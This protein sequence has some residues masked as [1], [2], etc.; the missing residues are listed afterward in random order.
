[1]ADSR[2][3]WPTADDYQSAMQNLS[4]SMSDT[5]LQS[6]VA[7][8][9]I[10]GMPLL[11]SGGIADVY[12]VECA[13]TGN[14][15]AVKCF[16]R[17]TAGLQERYAKISDCL[18]EKRLPFMVDFEYLDKGIRIA[19]HWYPI[20][21]MQW[22][23]GQTLGEYIQSN[24]SK[25]EMLDQ[26]LLLWVK[27]ATWLDRADIAHADLQ[28]G[29]VMLVPVGDDGTV[30]LKLVDYDGM[31]VPALAGSQATE[32]GHPNFQHPQRAR[33]RIYKYE[34]DRFSH[35][36]IC[37]AI[38]SLRVGGR[39][40]WSDFDNED[41]LLFT[42]K[43]FEVPSE[44]RLMKELWT[45]TDRR[46]HTLLGNLILATQNPLQK[47]PLIQQL[48]IDGQSEQLSVEASQR[49][50]SILGETLTET[51]VPIAEHPKLKEIET[52]S[53]K[54]TTPPHSTSSPS[55]EE[56]EAVNTWPTSHDFQSAMLNLSVSMSDSELQSGV[57]AQNHLGLPL[58]YS[59]DT[60]EVYRV[61]CAS[62][63]NT[64]AVKCFRQPTAELQERYAK[65]SKCLRE[66]RLPFMVNF[67]F[68][69][70]G[71][72]I[73]N[74]WYPIL[75]MQW[76][77]GKT[78]NEYVKEI[79]DQPRM[80]EQLLRLWVKLAQWL[81]NADIA[82]GDLQHGS[83]LIIPIGEDGTISLKLVDYDGMWVPALA[84]SKA[85]EL[86][87]PNFQHPQRAAKYIYSKD[88]DRFSHL[89]ICTAISCLK[90]GGRS[91]W[92]GFD[93][94]D[95]VLFMAKDFALP[96]E[97]RLMRELWTLKDP[98]SRV[99]VGHLIVA[100]RQ[101]LE[102]V[103]PVYDLVQDHS[104]TQ[105]RLRE[106]DSILSMSVHG[107][108][109]QPSRNVELN[110]PTFES[111]EIQGST[112]NITQP[113][114]ATKR[115][116]NR[117]LEKSDE[118]SKKY[119]IWHRFIPS[120][121]VL[122]GVVIVI[123]SVI[124]I[125]FLESFLITRKQ[126]PRLDNSFR[127]RIVTNSIGMEL[128]RISAGTFVMGSPENESYHSLNEIQH[129]VTISKPF[130]ISTTE[131]TQEQWEDVM[132][133]S[134]WEGQEYCRDGNDYPAVYVSWSDAIEFCRRL[135]ESEGVE[136]SLP[137]EAQWEYACRAGSSSAYNFGESYKSLKDHAWYWNNATR[138]T[139]AFSFGVSPERFAREVAKKRPNAWGLFDMH[140][141]AAEWCLDWYDYRYYV[142]SPTSDPHGPTSGES[143]VTRGGGF[144][145]GSA[146]CRSANRSMN[147]LRTKE[148]GL[149][150]RVLVSKQ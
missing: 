126:L 109:V 6:G 74:H 13:S 52:T 124:G 10:M 50:R 97:S 3:V 75:K 68:L 143:R 42:A 43:D 21:K 12:R 137:T 144:L 145:N 107:H 76:V 57:A 149:G 133:T 37:T 31:W 4:L 150:F 17:P 118:V 88:V 138:D 79:L 54:A 127:E 85:M 117:D 115:S 63:G 140:G 69:D 105:A 122:I 48:I 20:L 113:F 46:V 41:N 116:D 114:V 34:V 129:E 66:K 78:L 81:D 58:V 102:Q 33:D 98:R 1:M 104:T 62:T 108:P 134:P 96:H 19:N 70:K 25:P 24:L 2:K 38:R 141:N 9:N 142:S 103:P 147:D 73:A 82:H 28:H 131:T 136:Y 148:S 15:W 8:E 32:L 29:N 39:S 83:V 139:G 27:L 135:S 23:E 36:V 35:L 22:V 5:E 90:V 71:V 84:G 53:G 44:S 112:G 72:R 87:H 40:L 91:L 95:N 120:I 106:V 61:E 119:F 128:V 60:A 132:G 64:W 56:F 125:V 51:I 100:T 92:S 11:Y 45:L 47:T 123:V 49:I 26:L 77:E 59:G 18:Q 55:K 7:A 16:K 94:F 65:I 101:N 99:M 80:L 93:N 67:E 121:E 30:S 89:V 130:Y 111:P 86:G 14:T 146:H 110:W